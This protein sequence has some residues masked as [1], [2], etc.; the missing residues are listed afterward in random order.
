MPM[1][2]DRPLRDRLHDLYAENI[3]AK[4]LRV[5]ISGLE[6]NNPPTRY[7]EHVPQTPIPIHTTT[8][9]TSTSPPTTHTTTTH[10]S[11]I[12]TNTS[13][14]TT[15]STTTT[16]SSTI[17][18][19]VRPDDNRYA[20]RDM[21][22]W[23]CGFFPGSL[24]ALLD[25]MVKYPQATLPR[26]SAS[27]I[28]AV[29]EQLVT[30]AKAWSDPILK[31]TVH[32]TDTHGLGFM[33]MPSL[34]PRWEL[35]HDE[36]ALEG[37]VTAARSLATRFDE[38]VGAIRSS[39]CATG[40]DTHADINPNQGGGEMPG[41]EDFLVSIDSM[42][43]M[44]LLYYAAAQTGDQRLA[45]IATR[46]A[47]T[48][49]E[50]HIDHRSIL[51]RDNPEYYAGDACHVVSFDPTTGQ[52]RGE[53]SSLEASRRRRHREF[54]AAADGLDSNFNRRLRSSPKKVVVGEPE[55]SWEEGIGRFVPL[56]DF[57]APL[58]ETTDIGPLRDSSA[59]VIAATGMLILGQ[60]LRGMGRSGANDFLDYAVRIVKE[61]LALCLAP[62][63]AKITFGS[64][65]EGEIKGEIKV[66]DVIKGQTFDGILKHATANYSKVDK[67]GGKRYW[68]HGLVYADYYLIDF[69]NRLLRMDLA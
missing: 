45:E 26:H 28:S 40:V 57:K 19:N 50:S 1:P 65:S 23:T 53:S 32:R 54:L 24:Y 11:T 14:T 9:K 33:V 22:F 6:N 38:R 64:D 49:L 18:T 2:S 56:W 61:T 3:T 34:R 35:L 8:T 27:E 15:T 59:G 47:K 31:E 68:D 41:E 48:V 51:D 52:K 30:L 55:K 66:D 12:T 25:R 42:G 63:K 69:G 43:D 21:S 60:A 7:P 67:E 62:E 37:I 17:T 29:R 44:D 10:S 58:E 4:I 16:E 36:Q 20:Y 46:H 5:A 13:N 39:C